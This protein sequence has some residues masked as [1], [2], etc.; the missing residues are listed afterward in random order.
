MTD[1]T[2]ITEENYVVAL[3]ALAGA[4]SGLIT[5]AEHIDLDSMRSIVSKY[6]TIAPFIDP[7]SYIRGGGMNLN[8]QTAFLRAVG[9]FMTAI[10][11][12]DRRSE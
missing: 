6:E 12:I 3:N 4:A 7:T 5:V 10:K 11:K 9:E 1:K 8:D 2:E